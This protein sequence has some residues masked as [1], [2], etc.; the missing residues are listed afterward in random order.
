MVEKRDRRSLKVILSILTAIIIVTSLI[1]IYAQGYRISL[2]QGI[3]LKATGI[4]SVTSKPKAAS[5]YINNHLVTATDNIVNLPPGDYDVKIV[6]DGYTP[7]QKRISLK[8]EVVQQTDAYLFRTTPDIRSITFSGA[9]NPVLSPTGTKIIYAV[10]SASASKNNG[11]YQYDLTNNL[12]PLSKNQ[13]KLIAVNFHNLDWSKFKFQFSPDGKELLATSQNGNISY[14]INLEEPIIYQKL[15]DV[16]LNKSIIL[17]SWKRA[18]SVQIQESIKKLPAVFQNFVSTASSSLALFSSNN[19]RFLYLARSDY[20][21]DDN[22]ILPPPN[23]STQAQ[24]RQ[25]KKGNYYVYDIKDDT[26]FKIGNAQDLT[27]LSWLPDSNNLIFIQQD[28]IFT[29]DYDGTNLRPIF[30]GKFS[31][32][33]L[34]SKTD[35]SEII[36]LDDNLYALSIR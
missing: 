26:N 25:I 23:Q 15:Q 1:I 21:L 8:K 3:N 36:I 28:K 30:S 33:F 14:L 35:G 34:A 4:L 24:T 12:L 18:E 6:K 32:N 27:L 22:L 31:N 7:W 2:E 29:I 5:V 17:A 9:I 13:P 19:E 16:T 11:L 10:A 20:N